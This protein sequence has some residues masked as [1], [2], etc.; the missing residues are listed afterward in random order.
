MYTRPATTV[1]LASRTGAGVP[2]PPGGCQCHTWL[3]EAAFDGVN[4]VARLTEL[5]CG[6]CRYCGQSRLGPAAS[7]APATAPWDNGITPASPNA[8][9]S[10][11]IRA[12]EPGLG[13]VHPFGGDEWCCPLPIRLPDR[14]AVQRGPLAGRLPAARPSGELPG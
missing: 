1:G 5:C 8:A 3:A 4:A 11:S 14:G 13:I 2:L 6:P 10:V 12:R 7:E 9:V